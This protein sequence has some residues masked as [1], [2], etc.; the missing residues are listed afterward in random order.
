MTT[1]DSF[2]EYDDASLDD[3]PSEDLHT[4]EGVRRRREAMEARRPKAL[5]RDMLRLDRQAF[6]DEYRRRYGIL[7]SA[8]EWMAWYDFDK[9]RLEARRRDHSIKARG[10]RR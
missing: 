8:G 2:I 5:G 7:P 6:L 4:V 1:L 10:E 3:L 9:R